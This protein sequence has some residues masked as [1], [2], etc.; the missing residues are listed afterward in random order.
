MYSGR[1]QIEY[2]F[3]DGAYLRECLN[4]KVNKFFNGDQI[5]LDYTQVSRSFQ[6]TFYYDCLPPNKNND[7]PDDYEERIL[8]QRQFFD[9]LR[10]LSGFHVY[11][12]TTSG[13]AHKARQK[14]VDIMIAVHMLSHTIRGNMAKATLLAGDLDFKPLIDALVQE[15]MYVTLWSDAS[16]T[17]KEL[18]Y[19]A[20]ARRFLNIDTIWSMTTD[21]FK[22]KHPFPKGYS[23]DR[24]D[25]EGSKL[26][27]KGQSNLGGEAYCYKTSDSKYMIVYRNSVNGEIFYHYCYHDLNFLESFLK[28]LGISFKWSA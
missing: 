14:Q 2:L 24:V 26:V 7:R 28:D 10:E 20:D 16:S 13:V 8:L 6:K 15:G 19:S 23:T 25:D 3:I 12:G 18:I 21:R 11:E 27:K 9:H 22:Q 5:E 17:S 1:R 4:D